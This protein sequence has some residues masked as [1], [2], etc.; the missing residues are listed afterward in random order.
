MTRFSNTTIVA[1]CVLFLA[2][3]TG[4]AYASVPLY[5]LF[6]QVT[7]FGGTTQVA[8]AAPVEALDRTIKVRFDANIA[9]GLPWEFR[10][11]QREVEVRIGEVAE[12]AYL[13]RSRASAP[14]TGTASF[15]VTPQ[16]AGAYFNKMACFCF[17]EQ[18][19]Q[20]DEEVRMPVTFFVDPAIAEAAETRGLETL[21]LSYTF[22]PVDE[23]AEIAA[24][25]G[26]AREGSD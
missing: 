1:A 18:T 11:L 9:P 10:P 2:G 26:D 13:S 4:L 12:V 14:T 7:G 17:N 19:L 22:Y 24:V 6:C 5:R 15:N 20:P 23:P 25:T 21:T 8:D 16:A 3:M